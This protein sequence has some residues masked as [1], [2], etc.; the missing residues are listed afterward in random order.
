MWSIRSRLISMI[1]EASKDSY[2]MEFGAMLKAEHE[3]I[4]EIAM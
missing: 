4:Y 3:V 1:M 2:P